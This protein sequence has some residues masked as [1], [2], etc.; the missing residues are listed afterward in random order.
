M[1]QDLGRASPRS[2][3]D[4]VFSFRING[5]KNSMFKKIDKLDGSRQNYI[6]ISMLKPNV[7]LLSHFVPRMATT[8]ALVTILLTMAGKLAIVDATL[9]VHSNSLKNQSGK[10][11][12][13]LFLEKEKSHSLFNNA[14]S[15]SSSGETL[16]PFGLD[17]LKGY[18]TCN[19]FKD[20][21]IK[22]STESRKA[23]KK[24]QLYDC[25]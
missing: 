7:A 2:I 18:Q 20:V 8:Y 3:N 16:T 11:L 25:Y 6:K 24:D 4:L 19:D 13:Q 14:T 5:I 17:I 12:N 1:N 21:A 9:I 15:S 10:I 23:I 22:F